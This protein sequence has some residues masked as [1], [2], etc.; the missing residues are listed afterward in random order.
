M[1]PAAHEGFLTALNRLTSQLPTAKPRWQGRG[2][3]RPS[4]LNIRRTYIRT[5]TYLSPG[6]VSDLDRLAADMEQQSGR[7]T[8]RGDIVRLAI[9][10]YIQRHLPGAEI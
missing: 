6:M 3:G 2:R 5:E 7:R 8:H 9:A 4:L 10:A 1:L